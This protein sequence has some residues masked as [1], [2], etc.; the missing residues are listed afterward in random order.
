M[1]KSVGE[2]LTHRRR[3]SRLQAH[4]RRVARLEAY[5][6]VGVLRVG[7]R[8]PE[9]AGALRGEAVRRAVEGDDVGVHAEEGAR[10][11]ID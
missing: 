5:L 10:H 9:L 2:R 7:L 6:D 8:H 4:R 3:A 11:G 1:Q